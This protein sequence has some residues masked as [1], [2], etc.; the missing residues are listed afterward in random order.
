MQQLGS[1]TLRQSKHLAEHRPRPAVPSDL[2]WP[3]KL[4]PI[5]AS[6]RMP[7]QLSHLYTCEIKKKT[8][9]QEPLLQLSV[10]TSI[11][12]R[13]D[14]RIDLRID[15]FLTETGK[16]YPGFLTFSTFQGLT[17]DFV[18]VLQEGPFFKTIHAWQ[19]SSHQVHSPCAVPLSPSTPALGRSPWVHWFVLFYNRKNVGSKAHSGLTS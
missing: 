8:P 19:S 10:R 16:L 9:T 4:R 12:S 15:S 5:T 7:G 6:T 18:N 14:S 11:D 17:Y 3:V 1:A 2:A 13:I